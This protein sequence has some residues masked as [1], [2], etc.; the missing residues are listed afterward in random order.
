MCSYSRTS[1]HLWNPKVHYR[2]HKNTPLVPILSQ[3]DPVHTTPSYCLRSILI[4]YT[5]LRLG[6]PSDIFPIFIPLCPIRVTC[7]AHLILLDL[8]ILII[9]GEECKLWSSSLCSFLQSPFTSCRFVT[10][11]E[12][13]G[14]SWK[15]QPD[16]LEM[17][18]QK[19]DL[20]VDYEGNTTD[21]NNLWCD[22]F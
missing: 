6:L 16:E 13:S 20:F 11:W 5:L 4:L 22:Y 18:E 9:L 15:L 17:A 10:G 7:P 3:I 1:Q 2:V 21:S 19:C 12:I 14:S 8:I